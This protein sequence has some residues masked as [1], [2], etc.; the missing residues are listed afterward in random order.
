M[1]NVIAFIDF[2]NMEQAKASLAMNGEKFGD[3]I[4]RVDL[5]QNSKAKNFDPKRTIFVG[6]L[7]F[8]KK[9]IC[10]IFFDLFRIS[11]F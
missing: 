11:T 5:Q 3:K 8:S 2:E 9:L 7:K 10:F 1:P 4:L 6:N